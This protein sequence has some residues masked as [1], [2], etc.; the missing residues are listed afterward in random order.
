[1]PNNYLGPMPVS[2]PRL[3]T[4][5]ILPG[6]QTPN[7]QF[8]SQVAKTGLNVATGG[9]SDIV[10]QVLNLIP[11]I[12]Q[13]VI[14]GRQLKQAQQIESQ[15][16]RP[17]ATIA[18]SVDKLVNYSYGQTLNQ[19]IPGG[20]MYRNEIKGA[21]SAG[22]QAASELGSGAE[23]YGMLGQLVGRQQNQYGDLARLIAQQVK[24]A[25][26]DY[27]NAL[28]TRAQE[29][30]RV[31]DWNKAQPYL[32]AAQIASQL[33][34]SGMKNLY[35]GGA[36]AFGAAAEWASPDFNSSVLWGKGNTAVGGNGVSNEE[37]MNVINSF[38][39]GKM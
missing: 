13:G 37:L 2:T 33:R 7:S 11:A 22:M 27:M 1:M 21:T 30:N 6:I 19:D 34:D 4:S 26:G 15:N 9:A 29:E 31:W 35:S 24:D 36:N 3:N 12:F 10:S 32:Q 16:Q 20:E 28:G 38:K 25:R 39:H 8:F 17:E 18:P 23:A 14:G 5:F